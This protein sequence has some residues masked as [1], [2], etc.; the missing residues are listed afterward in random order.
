MK[1]IWTDQGDYKFK[2]HA[3]DEIHWGWG[4]R[5]WAICGTQVPYTGSDDAA[6]EVTCGSCLRLLAKLQPIAGI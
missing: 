2:S 3:W 4:K 1:I 6:T 5:R